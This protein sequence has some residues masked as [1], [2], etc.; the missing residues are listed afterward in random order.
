MPA[1]CV[2][3]VNAK[4]SDEKKNSSF[5]VRIAAEAG[6]SI[7]IGRDWR[8]G[9][10]KERERESLTFVLLFSK[11]YSFIKSSLHFHGKQGSYF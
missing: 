8:G 3:V 10:K 2:Y 1:V 7:E 6:A 9:G 5:F 11:E 4:Y